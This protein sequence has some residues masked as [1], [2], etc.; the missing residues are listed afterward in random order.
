L[1]LTLRCHND[2]D[3]MQENTIDEALSS[4]EG[5][6]LSDMLDFMNKELVR[7]EEERR[8]QALS[9]LAE[10]QRRIREAEESGHR[11]EE[12]R[13]IREHDEIFKQVTLFPVLDSLIMLGRA[14]D[15]TSFLHHFPW[16]FSVGVISRS[17]I[18]QFKSYGLTTHT[19][20]THTGPIA[21][22]VPLK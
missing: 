20:H 16:F 5:E 14:F 21:L 4:V 1:M 19:A 8:I 9:M 10:R 17:K 22:F 15:F 6:T 7:L 12:E 11:Q 18:M 13:R 3:T 2:D